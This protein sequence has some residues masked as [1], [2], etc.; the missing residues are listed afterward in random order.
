MMAELARSSWELPPLDPG[1]LQPFAGFPRLTDGEKEGLWCDYRA[2]KAER[3]PVMLAMND[4]VFLLDPRF[5]EE[6]LGY[7]R[8]FEAAEA[9]LLVQLRAQ[10]LV[11]SRYNLFCDLPAGL[12]ERWQ[13]AP[14]FQNVY[15]AAA[16]GVPIEFKENDV[17]AVVSSVAD[18]DK[19]SL[20]DLPIDE[21]L[22]RGVYRIG[23]EMTH[24]M[25]ELVQG[26]TFFGRPIEV[27]PYAELGSDGPLTVAMNVRGSGILVD[28]IEDP[29][30]A[31]ELFDHLVAAALVRRRA[32][33]H[34]WGLPD[35]EEVWLA[36]D[37]IAT[38][39]VSQ[40]AQRVLPHH[41][42]WYDTLDPEHTK[43]RGM[44]LCGDATRHFPVIRERL[45]VQ[46]FD[47]GFPV[48]FAALRRTLG[49]EVEILGGVEVPR[50]LAGPPQAIYRRARAILA[51]GVLEG[52]RFVLREAN[53]L[54]PGVPWSHLAA[55]YQAA[56]DG[57]VF[58][59]A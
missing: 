24:R 42:K 12:P 59:P 16:L 30:Y 33:V 39:S 3:V 32:F 40:Y 50:L 18:A 55:M 15:E 25:R 28:L 29:D 38:I 51:S 17:P 5:N 45:G 56:F 6:R 2:G 14:F 31:R 35:P 7:A 34:Y 54:P 9:M 37:S 48:D 22:E 19:R 49:P 8:V 36:D 27:V 47:T 52:R 26:K 41:R 11:R 1:E 57:G 53:N 23:I 44:H 13:V 20:L 58:G 10:Y 46:T 4:R 21:P 43:R